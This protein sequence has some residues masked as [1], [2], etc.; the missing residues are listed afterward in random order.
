MPFI[1]DPQRAAYD[2]DGG[3][4]NFYAEDGGNRVLCA[5]T[6]EAL[7]DLTNTHTLEPEALVA[8]YRGNSD[9][10]AAIAEEKY[11]ARNINPDGYVVV[12]SA[13]VMQ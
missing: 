7:Q 13:D 6:E 12:T 1:I 4:V 8:L 5:V 2:F 9:I 11:R 3:R 10:I